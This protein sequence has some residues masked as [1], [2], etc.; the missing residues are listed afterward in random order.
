MSSRKRAPTDVRW[1]GENLV[2]HVGAWIHEDGNTWPE[3]C[4]RI[5]G[6]HLAIRKV[7]RAW[8]YGRARHNGARRLPYDIRIRI[9]N[10]V[11]VPTITTFSRTRFWGAHQIRRLQTVV[12]SAVRRCMG[13]HIGM[14]HDHGIT[15]AKLMEAVQWEPIRNNLARYALL[16][17]GHVARMPLGSRPRQFVFGWWHGH[18]G[19]PHAPS[20][21]NTVDRTLGGGGGNIVNR[22]VPF[23]SRPGRGCGWYTRSIRRHPPIRSSNAGSGRGDKAGRSPPERLWQLRT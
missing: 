4:K 10:S 23:G 18:H 21:P 19:Q 14:M 22:L 9:M 7:S 16:W 5:S 13:V 17:L 2:K 3:L 1:H 15:D 6:G 11:L 12:N 20:R 8:N